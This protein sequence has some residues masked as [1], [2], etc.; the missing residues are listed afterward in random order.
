MGVLA[1]TVQQ[2]AAGAAR[3]PLRRVIGRLT[4]IG[5]GGLVTTLS[6]LA[7]GEICRLVEANGEEILGQVVAVR[8]GR[9]VLAP[10][11]VIDGLS[12]RTE[13]LPLRDPFT[14][15]CGTGMLG[16]VFDGLG[17]PLDG[18]PAALDGMASRGVQPRV[19]PPLERPL[20]S[21]PIQTGIRVID[22]LNTLGVGQR[23]GVFG[24][25][26][27]GKSS[28]LG[29]LAR[30]ASA[31]VCVLALIGERGRE[32]RE[33][34]D[35]QLPPEFRERC[36][37]VASTSDRPAMERVIGAHVATSVAEHFREQGAHV[38]LLFDSVTR[39]AR[40]LR[41]VG[42]AAGEQPV[43]RGFT[44]S[45]YAELPRLIERCGGDRNGAITAIYT[46]LLENEGFGDPIAEEVKSLTDGHILLDS[47]LGQSGHYPAV[48][49]LGSVSRLMSE[50]ASPEHRAAASRFRALMARY[51][52]IELLVQVGEYASGSDPLADEA[53]R[54]HG[55]MT[56]FLVQL[57][58]EATPFAATLGRLTEVV[59][60]GA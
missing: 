35:R 11:G 59:S 41:E 27:G 57:G 45:V 37:V 9:A 53:L 19:T 39:F 5:P 43:R 54:R 46:V 13:V 24:P 58:R 50:I 31:D 33:F 60:D 8:D 6:D 18:R 10:L 36:V 29:A 52:E 2:M 14:F 1:S 20:I 30:N 44:P 48:D 40:A 47:K 55:A 7:M 42:L 21:Q 23:I 25:P 28:L 26:G 51:K 15:R 22:G 16:G 56:E 32:L 34:L 49:V 12:S 17:R 38:L 3:R 4:E